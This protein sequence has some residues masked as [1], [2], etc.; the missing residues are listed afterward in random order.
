M[1]PVYV[2]YLNVAVM[3]LLGLQ[4]LTSGHADL[5]PICAI[6]AMCFAVVDQTIAQQRRQI[7]DLEQRI[8]DLSSKADQP[9]QHDRG[10]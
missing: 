6:T 10:R 7:R 8:R 2:I 3:L 4:Q 5:S 1:L 9:A